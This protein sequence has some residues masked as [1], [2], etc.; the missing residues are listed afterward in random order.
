MEQIKP[1]K[2]YLLAKDEELKL[3]FSLKSNFNY[4]DEFN[5][6]KIVSL[7]ELFTKERNNS[8]NYRIYGNIN[9]LSFLRNKKGGLTQIPGLPPLPPVQISGLEDLFTES[10]TN[11]F[12]NF[13]NFFD[14]KLFRLQDEQVTLNNSGY[15]Y[16]EKLTAITT[17]SDYNLSFFAYSKNVFNERNYYFSFNTVDV[18]PNKLIKIDDSIV[19]DNSI[20][21]GFIPKI[22]IDLYEKRVINDGVYINEIDVSNSEFDY[23]AITFTDSQINLIIQGSKFTIDDF[24][25]YLLSKLNNLFRIYNLKITDNNI[26]T[27]LRFI[28]NY[29]DTGNG[30]YRLYESQYINSLTLKDWTGSSIEGN[31]VSF[32]KETYTFKNIVEKE[33]IIK[34]VMIDYYDGN[35]NTFQNYVDTN[36]SGFSYYSD[37]FNGVVRIDFFFKFK[38]FYK[39]ELKKY[40]QFL[41]EVNKNV[42][43]V[44]IPKN[45]I[46]Y[47][48]KYI[49]RDLLTYGDPDN[50]DRPFINNNH[51]VFDNIIFYLKPELSDKNTTVLINEFLLS[52]RDKGY[53]F[54]KDNIKL[55]V[56]RKEA[57]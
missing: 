44:E 7:S 42:T 12:F 28:R 35:L 57:C 51:Y 46:L 49:W 14:L 8:T 52:F 6:S 2:R 21:L 11:T 50:Y 33:Y 10:I 25:K 1:N 55:Y 47:D 53:T 38:P 9:Y 3:N 32:D 31:Y 16:K 19:Y 40:S 23:S 18:N 36:Y 30:D 26:T 27:N 37:S 41:N 13:E 4:L 54:N 17:P 39:I 56:Q 5:N 45:A 20:Y 48:D 34:L 22:N 15:T 43:N 24:K 29:L